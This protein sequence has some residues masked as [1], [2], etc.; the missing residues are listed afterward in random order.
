MENIMMNKSL[1]KRNVFIRIISF[2][3][4]KKSLLLEIISLWFVILFLYTGIAKLLDFSVF[5]AQLEESPVLEPVAPVIIWTLPA[6]E[7]ILCILLFFEKFRLKGLY[8]TFLIMTMFTIYV[9]VMLLTSPELPCSCGG[10]IEA[11]SWPGHLI[12]NALMV[13]IS[14][15]AIRMQKRINQSL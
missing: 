14:I 13:F 5:K 3:W 15:A 2:S 4:V 12:F 6:V 7:F 10:I 1:P 11:L 9:L 8:G